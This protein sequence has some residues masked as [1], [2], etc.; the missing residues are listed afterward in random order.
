MNPKKVVLLVD[1]DRDLHTLVKS[2]LRRLKIENVELHSATDGAEALGLLPDLGP[3]LGLILSDV[4]MPRMDGHALL[5]RARDTGYAG[6]FVLIGA[7]AHAEHDADA[8]VEKDHLLDCLPE[9]LTR[10]LV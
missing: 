9:L 8:W 5:R 2:R 10:W 6:P 4:N 3:G 1:D 7:L